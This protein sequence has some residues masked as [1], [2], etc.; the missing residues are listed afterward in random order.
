MP[1]KSGKSRKTISYNI[2]EMLRSST[3]AQDK[4]PKKRRSMAAAASYGKAR[5]S[6]ARLPRKKKKKPFPS[7][8]TAA[9]AK[10]KHKRQLEEA[11]EYE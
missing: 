5:E 2:G 8:W 10:R 3:F 11:L 7:I 6:G 4:S 9:E 1:L